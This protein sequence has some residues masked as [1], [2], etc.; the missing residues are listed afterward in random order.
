MSNATTGATSIINQAIESVVGMI[1]GL[2]PFA[3][4]TR[5]A[6]GTGNYLSCEIGP[7]TPEIVFLDK[8]QYIPIDFTINGKHTDLLTLSDT[9]NSIHETLTMLREY[10]N[11]SKWEIV[12]IT[13]MT[14]PQIIGREDNNAWIMA[15]A[16]LVKVATFTPEPSPEPEPE[17][18]PEPDQ[19]TDDQEPGPE[20]AAEQE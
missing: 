9:M 20:P 3:T 5:G 10:P 12:D 6:L 16:L 11:G 14:E 2:S 18:D 17:P 4:M 15:S 19:E 1:N 13:T 7:T 8:N